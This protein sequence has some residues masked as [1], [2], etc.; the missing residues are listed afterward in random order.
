M[1][2]KSYLLFAV[3]SYSFLCFTGIPAAA[4]QHQ[5][6]AKGTADR[7]KTGN[8][9][10]SPAAVNNAQFETVGPDS[11]GPATLKAQI[12]LDRAHFSPGQID[13]TYGSNTKVAITSYQLA[14]DLDAS[15]TVDQKTWDSLTQDTSDVLIPYTTTQ[16]DVAGPFHSTPE[17]TEEQA[18]LDALTYQ[19]ANEQLG[20][21]FHISPD[22]LQKLNSGADLTKAGQQLMVPNVRDNAPRGEVD[23]VVVTKS[24]TN[25]LA[26]DK[27][28]KVVAA[29]PATIGSEHDPLPIGNWKITVIQQDPIFYYHPELFWNSEPSDSKAKIAP[30]PNNPVGVVWIGLTKEHYGIHGTA[31]PELIG[32]SQSHGCIR[33][34]NWDA[35][36]L[37]HLVKLHM[38]VILKE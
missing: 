25:V 11:G 13:G 38:A 16:D 3:L 23:H 21:K 28:G 2:S 14:H 10:F 18:K 32:H 27:S 33:L 34:T 5:S 17:T 19:S 24:N 6:H 15:G 22:L 1:K 9:E 20:E 26:V 35:E 29:Y 36:E 30:G 31:E 12:L 8:R 37:S 7:V 4:A